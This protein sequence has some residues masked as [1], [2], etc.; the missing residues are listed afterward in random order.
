MPSADIAERRTRALGFARAP[1]PCP[2]PVTAAAGARWPVALR[3][4][5]VLGELSEASE[6]ALQRAAGLAAA[7]GA[8][9]RLLGWA[10]RGDISDG[11]LRARLSRMARRA[12][13]RSQVPVELGDTPMR[14]LREVLGQLGGTDL[15]VT[16]N[17]RSDGLASFWRPNPAVRLA[18]VLPVP[19]L[20]VNEPC[21][22]PYRQALA[23]V[24]LQA[25]PERVARWAAA[26]AGDGELAL[27]HVLR[28]WR[29]GKL[30][31]GEDGLRWLEL[32]LRRRAAQLQ[33]VA[34]TL[35]PQTDRLRVMLALGDDVAAEILVRRPAEGG[36]LVV[37]GRSTE[38]PWLDALLGSVTRS[39]L[40]ASP[41]DVLVV[42]VGSPLTE[43][44]Q[45]G[46]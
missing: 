39:V 20:V 18:G 7:H 33:R 31:H 26:L 4:I 44:V 41:H 5:T 21:G 37:V 6:T 23:A 12:A 32:D 13:R 11:L 17:R 15:V 3:S 14:G 19:L 25:E 24:D 34:D 9:L 46:R 28:Q 22:L 16:A 35:Q 1:S 43:D 42:P 27:L 2:E 45:I 30:R 8:R 40:R 38:A 29:P 10:G 36:M